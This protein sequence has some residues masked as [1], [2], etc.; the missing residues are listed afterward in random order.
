MLRRGERPT[1]AAETPIDPPWPPLRGDRV[2]LRM[3]ELDDAP[4]LAA[5]WADPGIQRFSPVPEDR[6][7]ADAESWVGGGAYRRTNR[8]SI[9]MVICTPEDPTVMGEVGL[10]NFNAGAKGAMLG[11]WMHKA[12]RGQGLTADAVNVFVEWS[13]S[14]QALGLELVVAKV[15]RDNAASEKLLRSMGFRL[16]RNDTDGHRLFTKRHAGGSIDLT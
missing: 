4:S 15:H 12:Y 11:Y 5:A 7:V 14:P 2:L 10:W 13:M 3:W 1:I 6:T 9:D 16:E 8:I